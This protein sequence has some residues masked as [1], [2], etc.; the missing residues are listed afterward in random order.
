MTVQ[1]LRYRKEEVARRGNEIYEFQVHPQVEQGNH[2]KF[3]AINIET[4]S[5]EF[6]Q[7]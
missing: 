3:V 4:G 6:G 5:F 7:G 2:S 1:P